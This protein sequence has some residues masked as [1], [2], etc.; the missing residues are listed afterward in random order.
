M[1][2]FRMIVCKIK[3]LH[4]ILSITLLNTCVNIEYISGICNGSFSSRLLAK[5]SLGSWYDRYDI[6]VPWNVTKDSDGIE[7][8]SLDFSD[9]LYVDWS[10]IFVIHGYV[11]GV[12]VHEDIRNVKSFMRQVRLRNWNGLLKIKS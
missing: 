3:L 10:K 9:Q 8:L 6:A 7:V 5:I 11:T 1:C 12:N 2:P 4:I